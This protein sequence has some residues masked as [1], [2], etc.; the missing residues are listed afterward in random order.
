MLS[1]ILYVLF[2]LHMMTEDCDSSITDILHYAPTSKTLEGV[3]DKLKSVSSLLTIRPVI[4]F[5]QMLEAIR[6][7]EKFKDGTVGKVDD[8]KDEVVDTAKDA[9]KGVENAGNAIKKIFR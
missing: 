8:A 1:N 7:G 3:N 4:A 5:I 9:K 6:K 2:L